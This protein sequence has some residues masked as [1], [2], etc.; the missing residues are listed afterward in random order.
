MTHNEIRERLNTLA[1]SSNEVIAAIGVD[2]QRDAEGFII[3]TTDL[4]IAIRELE[5]VVAVLS[6]LSFRIG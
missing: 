2:L 4:G 6:R 5:H 3:D 1:E